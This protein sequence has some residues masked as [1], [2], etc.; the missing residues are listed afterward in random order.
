ML[1]ECVLLWAIHYKTPE[2]WTDLGD[3]VDISTGR[4]IMLEVLGNMTGKER[5]KES[6]SVSSA[7]SVPETWPQ[8]SD[9]QKAV[10]RKMVINCF[11]CLWYV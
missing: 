3:E 4:E 8:T 6:V 11:L 10:I 5:L 2:I 7:V 9:V 1:L